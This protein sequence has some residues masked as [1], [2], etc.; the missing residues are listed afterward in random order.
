MATTKKKDDEF[1]F[2]LLGCG[3]FTL[4]LLIVDIFFSKFGVMPVWVLLLVIIFHALTAWSWIKIFQHW[5]DPNK[6]YWR[7][8][9]IVA[10]IA[11]IMVVLGHRNDW[12]GKQEFLPKTG[13]Q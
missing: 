9:V 12:I 4:G 7:K 10:A 6:D 5:Q 2:I 8:V 1:S 3:I 13:Q 11:G